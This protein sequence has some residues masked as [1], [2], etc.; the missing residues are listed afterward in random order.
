MEKGKAVRM[1][2]DK[3]VTQL[4]FV[5]LVEEEENLKENLKKACNLKLDSIL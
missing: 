3:K 2:L 5:C 4:S 1:R